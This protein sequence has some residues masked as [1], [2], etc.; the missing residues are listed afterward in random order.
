M[1]AKTNNR[2]R[3]HEVPFVRPTAYAVVEKRRIYLW[4][5]VVVGLGATYMR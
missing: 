3:V 1:R 2:S 5:E 4:Y